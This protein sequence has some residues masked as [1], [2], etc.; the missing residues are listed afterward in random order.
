MPNVAR[1]GDMT[2]GKCCCHSNPTCRTKTGKVIVSSTDQYSESKGVGKMT[3]L[4]LH[5]CGHV[6][7]I[8]VSSPKSVSN[9][10]GK[11]RVGDMIV[12]CYKSGKIITSA[13]KHNSG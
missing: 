1:M 4:I 13:V 7:K 11:G 10:Q 9:G 8:V 5:T 6:S 2:I 3:N 12:G